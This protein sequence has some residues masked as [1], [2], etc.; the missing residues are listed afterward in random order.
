MTEQLKTRNDDLKNITMNKPFKVKVLLVDDNENNLMSMKSIFAE[1][2]YQIETANSGKEAL[3]ILLKDWD[4]ALI[5]MDVE[6]PVLN[7]FETAELIYEREKLKHIPIIFITA[8]GHG[9]DNV[10]K[11]YKAGAV[12]YIY[13][14]IRPELLRAK[15]HVF[16][17]LYRKNHQLQIQEQK[18]IAINKNLEMEIKDRIASEERAIE[19]NKQ[20]LENINQLEATNKELD[21]FAYMASHDLQEPL[22]KIK[23]FSERINTKHSDKLDGESRIYLD[24]IQ[25]ASGRMQ[26]L[27][28]DIFTLSKITSSKDSKENADLNELLNEVVLEMDLLIQE[29]NAVVIVE[30]LP[31]LFVNKSLMKRL[32]QNLI[33]N[34]IKYSQKS[35]APVIRITSRLEAGYELGGTTKSLRNKFYRIYVQDNG[36]GFDQQYAEQVFTMFKRLHINPEFEGTGIGLAICKKIVEEHQGF[37]SAKS[38]VNEGTTFTISLPVELYVPAK[39]EATNFSLQAQK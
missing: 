18:L 20:L 31:K 4:F 8:N 3:K 30:K 13:K 37:I 14:P 6:M 38:V 19:L 7:G 23:I 24:K 25:A 17:E 35:L 39:T 15:V 28:N 9:D 33:S 16:M 36:L 12:D 5:L 21:C 27:I 34:S 1:D 32:F 22:R 2:K 11:G 10:F 29:K 26:N